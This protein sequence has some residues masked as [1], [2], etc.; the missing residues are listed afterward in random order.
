L[1]EISNS[2]GL[3]TSLEDR[4]G[5]VEELKISDWGKPSILVEEVQPDLIQGSV[6]YKLELEGNVSW[7]D[8][9]T[10][11]YDYEEGV[12]WF[13][14]KKYGRYVWSVIV[15]VDWEVSIDSEEESMFELIDWNITEPTSLVLQLDEAEHISGDEN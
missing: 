3:K 6:I 8:P 14:D 7:E 11:M 5:D 15:R 9:A 13:R 1:R 4:E 12:Y 10:G 2:N